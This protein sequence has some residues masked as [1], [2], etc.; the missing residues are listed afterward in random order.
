MLIRVSPPTHTHTCSLAGLP[1]TMSTRCIYMVKCKRYSD[2][3]SGLTGGRQTRV[4]VTVAHRT[5]V[6][7]RLPSTSVFSVTCVPVRNALFLENCKSY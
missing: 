5:A 1:A 4:L 7:R 6:K 3:V 2:N